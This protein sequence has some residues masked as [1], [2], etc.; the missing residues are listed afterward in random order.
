MK[1][2]L[3]TVLLYVTL[4]YLYQ[5][6]KICLNSLLEGVKRSRSWIVPFIKSQICESVHKPK[7]KS[8]VVFY[9]IK[10]Y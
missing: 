2:Y 3:V 4:I 5:N 7:S 6:K 8:V 10:D 9:T 1:T